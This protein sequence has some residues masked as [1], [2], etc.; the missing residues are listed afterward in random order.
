MYTVP[1]YLI[2]LTLSIFVTVFV[3]RTLSRNGEVYLIDGFVGNVELAKS[4]NHMLVVGFYL[5]NLGFV[6]LRMNQSVPLETI[7]QLIVYQTANIG[8]VLIVLGCMHFFNMLVIH[9]YRDSQLRKYAVEANA[10]M[11]QGE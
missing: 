8:F 7:E 6:F 10:S 5:L 9:K 11:T 2:Y 3:S 1:A 4:L